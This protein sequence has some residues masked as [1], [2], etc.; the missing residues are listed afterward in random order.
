MI[1]YE[2]EI[3]FF[4]GAA[5]SFVNT[6]IIAVSKIQ[7]M[8]CFLQETINITDR[9]NTDT[10]IMVKNLWNECK[11]DIIEV[12]LPIITVEKCKY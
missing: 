7:I 12:S 8:K 6:K 1:L 11:G 9:K 5:W 4:D 2:L 10:K 3:R